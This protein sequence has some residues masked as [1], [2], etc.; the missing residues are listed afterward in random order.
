LITVTQSAPG[1][2]AREHTTALALLAELQ[3]YIEDMPAPDT[4]GINWGHV[5]NMGH[6]NSKLRELLGFLDGTDA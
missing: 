6:V 1:A 4:D 3:Q 2:Y 5:G